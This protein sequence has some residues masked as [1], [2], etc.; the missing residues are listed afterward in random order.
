[1]SQSVVSRLLKKHRETGSVKDRK[2]S[3]RP[4]AT[5]PR[6]V[7]LLFRMSRQNR[8]YSWETL[9]THLCDNHRIRVSRQLVNSRLLQARL[10]SRRPA[11]RPRLTLR[12]KGERLDWARQRQ[13]WHLRNWRTVLWTDE[14]RFCLYLKKDKRAKI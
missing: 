1:M 2:C 9:R 12:H 14:S 5:T 3:G 13:A 8:F 10:R 11:K 6:Q 4:K 7:S